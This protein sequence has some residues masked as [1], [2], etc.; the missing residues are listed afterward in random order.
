[1][2]LDASATLRLGAFYLPTVIMD[3]YNWSTSSAIAG[4]DPEVTF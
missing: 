1:M 2:A 3:L 4:V